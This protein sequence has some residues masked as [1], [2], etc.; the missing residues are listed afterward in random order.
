[1]RTTF[2]PSPSGEGMI[3]DE[4]NVIRQP[5]DEYLSPSRERSFGAAQTQTPLRGS[6]WATYTDTFAESDYRLP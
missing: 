5:S 3:V 2:I 6:A 4:T 1:M